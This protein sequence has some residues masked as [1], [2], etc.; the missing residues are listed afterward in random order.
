MILDSCDLVHNRRRIPG[1]AQP[2][3]DR[4]KMVAKSESTQRLWEERVRKERN[5]KEEEE[6]WSVNKALSW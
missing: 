4:R 2:K 5:V 6:K 1:I 3:K